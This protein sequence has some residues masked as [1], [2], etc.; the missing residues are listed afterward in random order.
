MFGILAVMA[1]FVWACGE[2]VDPEQPTDP[3]QGVTYFYLKEGQYRIYDVYEI[4][5]AAVDVSD[6]SEYQIREEVGEPFSLDESNNAYTIRRFTRPDSQTDWELDSVWSARVENNMAISVENNIPFVKLVFPSIPERNWDRNLFNTQ[7]Q[8]STTILSYDEPYTVGLNTFLNAMEVE[9]SNEDDSIT[10]R[11]IRSE[12]YA[13]SIGL[14]LKEYNR[15]TYCSTEGLCEI[16]AGIIQS[17]RYYRER[18]IESGNIYEQE[19]D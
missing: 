15:V 3:D 6:T 9:I 7:E 12:V 17:G 11:D 13:D 19:E 1:V 4:R 8:N 10:T 5:Y 2:D 16:G 14:V 18:L